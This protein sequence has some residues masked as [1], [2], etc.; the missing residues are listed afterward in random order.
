ME[1]TQLSELKPAKLTAK[2][3]AHG[4]AR[5]HAEANVWVVRDGSDLRKPYP[6]ERAHLQRA[7]RLRGGGQRLA[8]RQRDRPRLVLGLVPPL[9]LSPCHALECRRVLSDR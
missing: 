2:P 7:K 3:Q 1:M 5:L 4:L 9:T 6:R 8:L